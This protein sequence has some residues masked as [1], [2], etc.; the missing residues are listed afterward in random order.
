[1]MASALMCLWVSRRLRSQ[2][3]SFGGAMGVEK[4]VDD[5]GGLST[6]ALI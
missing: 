6:L 1:M 4:L 2:T 5:A 3:A